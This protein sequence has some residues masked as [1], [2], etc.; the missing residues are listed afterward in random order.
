MHGRRKRS[1]RPAPDRWRRQRG[2]TL[3]EVLVSFFILFVVTLAVLELISLSISVN[4]GSAARTEMSYKAQLVAET[5][6]LQH[7]FDAPQNFAGRNA[8][9]CPLI[10]GTVALPPSGCESFWGPAGVN[11]WRAD[12]PYALEYQISTNGGLRQVTVTAYPL[13]TGATRYPGAGIRNKAVRY[14]AQL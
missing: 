4:L 14:V 2:L 8:V 5:V 1:S 12:A 7:F 10:D 11:A 9:C 13:E 6:R 3:I